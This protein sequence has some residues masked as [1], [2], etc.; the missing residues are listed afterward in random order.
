[1]NRTID[2][3]TTLVNLLGIYL[4]WRHWGGGGGGGGG[5]GHVRPVAFCLHF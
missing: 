2:F 3:N 1:M 4:L 5:G